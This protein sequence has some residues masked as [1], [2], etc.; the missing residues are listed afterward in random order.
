MK[1]QLTAL[2]KS[3]C[4]YVGLIILLTVAR[5]CTTRTIGCPE[6]F[7]CNSYIRMVDDLTQISDVPGHHA[8]RVF[9]ILLVRFLMM[10]GASV[11]QS[12][13]V[14]SGF[15]YVF[16]G[17]LAYWIIRKVT[18]QQGWAFLWSLLLLS[19]H[20]AIRIPLYLVYQSN[21]ALVYP[22][23]I[24]ILWAAWSKK[25]HVTFLLAILGALTRQNVFVLGFLSLL[26]LFKQ[27]KRFVTAVYL[28]VLTLI[29]MG[30]QNYYQANGVFQEL[31]SPPEGFFSL[32]RQ[33]EI[34]IESQMLEL[35][36]VIAPFIVMGFKPLVAFFKTHW[37][38]FIY[39][40]ITIGQ[41]YL[42]YH[43]TGNNLPRLA[44]QGVWVFALAIALSFPYQR[45]CAFHWFVF[46]AFALSVYLTW[47]IKQRLWFT[48]LFVFVLLAQALYQR[49]IVSDTKRLV[50]GDRF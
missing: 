2:L 3:D 49:L 40:G 19:L 16:F 44:L 15:S 9:P 26:Y 33:W 5:V 42:G 22:I 30:L 38:W 48:A 14:I 23:G 4:F 18:G 39:A 11:E 41:P 17:V 46:A 50:V 12:F 43:L 21:D 1:S 13:H 36:L 27:E 47:G 24:G 45:W 6:D 37:H 31:L 34:L 8:M 28:V 35:W 32:T 29:Y 25:T 10:F 20:E 7:D